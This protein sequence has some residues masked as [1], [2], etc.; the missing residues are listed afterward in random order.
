VKESFL[1]GNHCRSGLQPTFFEKKVGKET[2]NLKKMDRNRNVA[3]T[4]WYIT[5][6]ERIPSALE[7][8]WL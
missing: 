4:E 5:A 1:S 2:L 8:E 7:K 3:P 6:E